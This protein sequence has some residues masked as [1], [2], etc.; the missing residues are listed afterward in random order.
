MV[1]A[2]VVLLSVMVG[3]VFVGVVRTCDGIFVVV[4]S[5][6]LWL[7]VVDISLLCVVVGVMLVVL[8]SVISVL[9][10]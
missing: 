2:L 10:V 4:A 9:L 8:E 5:V 3:V 6:M 7:M 1:V